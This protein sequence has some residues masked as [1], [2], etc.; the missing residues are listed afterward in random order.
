MATKTLAMKGGP[1]FAADHRSHDRPDGRRDLV[2]EAGGALT[3]ILVDQPPVV[4]ADPVELVFDHFL[5]R[6]GSRLLGGVEPE[7]EV[8]PVFLLD[9]PA[10]EG[11]IRNHYAVVVDI[12]DFT[13]GRAGKA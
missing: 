1:Q 11:R 8:D 6:P 10:D 5:E 4:H 9:V 12:R 2:E 7:V 3:E 13:L